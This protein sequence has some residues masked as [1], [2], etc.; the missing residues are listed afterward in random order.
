MIIESLIELFTCIIFHYLKQFLI[1]HQI[2]LALNKI[3]KCIEFYNY[4]VAL[5]LLPNVFSIFA[6]H[7]QYK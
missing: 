7:N 6:N 5:K 2:Y 3:V 4:F 1:K